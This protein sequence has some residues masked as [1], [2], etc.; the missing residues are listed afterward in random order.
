MAAGTSGL[1]RDDDLGNKKKGT[2]E[3]K[4][5]IHHFR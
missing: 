4:G 5:D 1:A 3:K 2:N